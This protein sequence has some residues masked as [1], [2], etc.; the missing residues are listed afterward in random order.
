LKLLTSLLIVAALSGCAQL[1][2]TRSDGNRPDAAPQAASTK[3]V[4]FIIPA[5]A[6]G[7]RDPR[8][9]EVLAKVGAVASKQSQPTTVVI[10]ALAQDFP[11]LNQSVRRGITPQRSGS[12][13]LENVTVGSCQPYSVQVKPAE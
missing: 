8:L 6:L 2:A 5:D 10:G 13:Q 1:Q 3:L 12:V 9:T 7:A 11:Y 4:D